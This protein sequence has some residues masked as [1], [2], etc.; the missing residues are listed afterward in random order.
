MNL[1]WEQIEKAGLFL[2]G[3][4]GGGW[5][6]KLYNARPE[7]NAIEISN[8]QSVIDSMQKR[9][10]TLEEKLDKR[11]ERIEALEKRVDKKHEVIFSAYGCPLIKKAEDC[12]V[13]NQWHTKCEN[14]EAIE[15]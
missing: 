12:V 6:L 3:A 11:E 7:K 15:G 14:C 2:A 10:D 1:N 4:F 8:L 9:L 5:F 13:I